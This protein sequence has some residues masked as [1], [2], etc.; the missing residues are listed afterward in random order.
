MYASDEYNGATA[1]IYTEV[2][3]MLLLIAL[4]HQGNVNKVKIANNGLVL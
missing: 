3:G 1:L 2:P 4:H